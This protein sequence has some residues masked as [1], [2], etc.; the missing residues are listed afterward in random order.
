M[1][2]IGY[3]HRSWCWKWLS[4]IDIVHVHMCVVSAHGEFDEGVT[5]PAHVQQRLHLCVA[6]TLVF[7]DHIVARVAG[8]DGRSHLILR[9]SLCRMSE[10]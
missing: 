10:Q 6:F 4:R 3:C 9:W 7:R 8:R 1:S 2:W 5:F